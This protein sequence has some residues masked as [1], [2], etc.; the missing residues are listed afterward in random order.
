M[1]I[2]CGLFCTCVIMDSF[3]FFWVH[4]EIQPTHAILE[5]VQSR[6]LP[7]FLRDCAEW[8]C[9]KILEL[10]PGSLSLSI[11]ISTLRIAEN[12]RSCVLR[13]S[14]VCEEH[15]GDANEPLAVEL[16]EVW[17]SPSFRDKLDITG[18]YTATYIKI[19]ILKQGAHQYSASPRKKP[20]CWCP[21]TWNFEKRYRSKMSRKR[22]RNCQAH[23]TTRKLIVIQWT[24]KRQCMIQKVPQTDPMAEWILSQYRWRRMW[25][26]FSSDLLLCVADLERKSQK[27]KEQETIHVQN[28]IQNTSNYSIGSGFQ[29]IL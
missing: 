3:H 27:H 20:S 2:V 13:F 25:T 8:R 18:R 17:C 14:S 9:C 28:T 26:R 23:K 12:R 29:P 19:E 15:N 5:A 1:M 10:K 11:T 22:C 24:R 16:E 7:T 6:T 21:P 4:H